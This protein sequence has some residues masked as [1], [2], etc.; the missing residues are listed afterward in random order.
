MVVAACS[1]AGCTAHPVGPARTLGS[2]ESKAVTT[3]ESALSAVETVRLAAATGTG[4]HAFGPYLSVLIS[5]QEDALAGTQG[6][7]GS[8][9][10]PG[11]RAD[12]LRDA[13]DRVLSDALHHVT[14][15]RL[16]ARRG[17]IDALADVG[18]DLSGDAA[19]LKRFIAEHGS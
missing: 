5:E 14:A 15:V 6:T 13:L 8:I 9:Q 3:A 2:Y 11:R 16:A 7:F 10:P 4:D 19:S 18:R 1:V 17:E 12:E